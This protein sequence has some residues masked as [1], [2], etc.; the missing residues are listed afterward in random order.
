[1]GERALGQRGCRVVRGGCGWDNLSGSGRAG[2]GRSSRGTAEGG[3]GAVPDTLG[4]G[5]EREGAAGP[6]PGEGPSRVAGDSEEVVSKP[7]RTLDGR[8]LRE[9]VSR[10]S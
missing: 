3:A 4:A 1:M 2:S 9:D 5:N 7:G 8:V 10:R 6:A